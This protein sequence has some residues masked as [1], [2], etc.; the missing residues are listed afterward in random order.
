MCA[1]TI[2]HIIPQFD[3]AAHS[4]HDI[5]YILDPGLISLAHAEPPSLRTKPR[6]TRDGSNETI[7]NTSINTKR[8]R[9]IAELVVASKYYKA[10]LRC[11]QFYPTNRSARSP[12]SAAECRQQPG[13][14]CSRDGC[15]WVCNR[16]CPKSKH[17][18]VGGFR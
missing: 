12:L 18:N 4:E 9:K 1:P 7:S 2:L 3:H 8:E 15:C 14:R 5:L 17:G 13:A 16:G 6:R 10:L 11:I